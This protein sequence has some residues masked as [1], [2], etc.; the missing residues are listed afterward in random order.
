MIFRHFLLSVNEVNAFILACDRTRQ[1][2]LV[3]A[4]DF[5]PQILNF[6]ER[7]GL[8]LAAV[9]ITHNHYDHV[10]GLAEYVKRFHPKIY[11]GEHRVGATEAIPVREGDEVPVGNLVGR[12]LETPGHTPDGRSLV[13]P[14]MVFTGDALFAG[15]VGGT[16]TPELAREQIEHIR[17]K[18]FALPDETE[19]HVGHGP[20]STVAV[21]RRYNPFFV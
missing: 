10:D 7:E 14:T 16:A 20:S 1:A 8:E 4:G 19:I 18:I 13:F 9:F 6:L 21:E 15:S 2:L 3:D 11:A 12:V 17:E 5:E